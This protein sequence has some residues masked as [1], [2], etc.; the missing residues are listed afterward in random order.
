LIDSIFSKFKTAFRMKI[1]LNKSIPNPNGGNDLPEG[2]EL[3]V[4]KDWGEQ[5]VADGSAVELGTF[6]VVQKKAA[7]APLVAPKA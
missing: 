6:K 7:T 4:T 1:K 5:L 3:D 2:L